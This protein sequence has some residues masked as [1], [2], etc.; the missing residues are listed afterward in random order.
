[1]SALNI[2]HVDK[3]FGSTQVLK[4]ISL[5][6]DSGEF[7]ILVGPSGCGKSTLMNA[8]A[9][10][11]PVTSGEIQIGGEDV[12]WHTPAERDIAMVF[13]S[14]ALY[15]S[16]NVRQNIAFGLEMRKMP[17]A[18]REEAVARVAE[19]LQITPLLDRKPSQL[20]GGQRQRV[21]MGRALARE[22]QIYL[23]DE[24]LSNLDAKLRV[25]MRTE[26]KKLHQRLGTTI[27]YVTHDQIEAMTLADRIAV[28]RDGEILQLGTPDEVYND[29]VDMFVA[30]FMGSPS[31]NFIPVTLVSGGDG[32]VLRVLDGDDPTGAP[33]ELPWP[34][35]RDAQAL[36]ARVGE[37][38]ILGLRPEHFVEDE[39]R[40]ETSFDG[41]RLEVMATVVEPTGA[42]ILLQATL[43]ETEATMRLGPKS[44]VAAGERVALRVDMSR[45]V[46]FEATSQRRVA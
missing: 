30:G 37:R 10:L 38:L 33:L 4:D 2:R 3:T 17:K 1:M 42:D 23:F 27:V 14:Y 6:I 32:Y 24:P 35:E 26:I 15:P 46:L 19:L 40:M 43:G 45:A 5:S 13:Q 22:P 34:A 31:M 25:E 11:E 44:R 28:M 7:L 8:I 29:P 16:M 20:S 12:T 36:Q 41:T 18:Q 21:A 9:G 39:T